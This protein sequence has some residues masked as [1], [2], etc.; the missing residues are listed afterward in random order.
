M[1][2]IVIYNLGG[3]TSSFNEMTNCM[4]E[5]KLYKSESYLKATFP[6][7]TH[8]SLL[9]MMPQ[10]PTEL[11]EVE[12]SYKGPALA[13]PLS[14]GFGPTATALS[15]TVLSDASWDFKAFRIACSV[16]FSQRRCDL[17]EVQKKERK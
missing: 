2:T 6:W 8:L 5:K 7:E 13:L 17:V 9:F 12:P 11:C 4:P 3:G 14:H 1:R 10:R 16:Q 15:L